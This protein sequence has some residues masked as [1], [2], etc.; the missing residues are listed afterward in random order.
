M[1]HAA[2]SLARQSENRR[3]SRHV[4]SVLAMICAALPSICSAV[5]ETPYTTGTVYEITM[6][7]V[8]AGMLDQYI[9]GLNAAFKPVMEEARKEGIVL[10]YK[11]L[12]GHS[13]N[14]A[15]FDLM[16]LKEYKNMGVLDGLHNRMEPITQRVAGRAQQQQTLAEKRAETR[17]ILG[18]KTM[19]ELFLK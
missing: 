3:R 16:I 4:L 18:I 17:E 5:D 1:K 19:R 13:S 10:S 15:D 7:K 8:K 9:S 6:V 14:S 11:V 2:T 12:F